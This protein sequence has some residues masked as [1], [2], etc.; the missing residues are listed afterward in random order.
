M[1]RPDKK[2]LKHAWKTRQTRAGVFAVLCTGS[3]GT[4]VATTRDL[5]TRQTGIWFSLRLGSHPNR[6]VQAAWAAHG[7]SCFVYEILEVIEQDPANPDQLVLDLRLRDRE[8][9]WR[10]LLGGERLTG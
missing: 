8:T 9:Y 3:A 5:D 1:G 2:A 6:Q 4:W 10:E 7:E